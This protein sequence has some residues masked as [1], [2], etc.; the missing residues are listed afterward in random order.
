MRRFA[1]ILVALGLC[2]NAHSQATDSVP[3]LL[4]QLK[5]E[6]AEKRLE[7]LWELEAL[8]PKAAAAVPDLAKLLADVLDEEQRILATLALGKIGKASLPTIEKLLDNE[9][10]TSR[11]Y[12]V[13]VVSLI[14]KDA[15][16]LSPRILKMLDSDSD[17]EVRIKSMQALVRIA[18]EAPEV[19]AA[20]LKRIEGKQD[21]SSAERLAAITEARH[22]G[23]AALPALAKVMRETKIIHIESSGQVI[24]SFHYVLDRHKNDAFAEKALPYAVE[25]LTFPD[26]GFQPEPQSNDGLA[27]LLAKHGEKLL[28]ALEKLLGDKEPEKRHVAVRALGQMASLLH[29]RVENPELVKKTL[30][31]LKPH[32][33]STDRSMRAQALMHLPVTDETRPEVIRML[34]DADAQVR[35]QAQNRLSTFNIDPAPIVQER[36]K[37]AT[38]DERI[39]C[40][41]GMIQLVNDPTAYKFLWA[42]LGHKDA[43]LRLQIATELAL[44]RFP[45][46]GIPQKIDKQVVPVLLAGLKSDKAEERLQASIGLS[47]SQASNAA[48]LPSILDGLDDKSME[49]RMN[50]LNALQIPNRP[51]DP[52]KIVQKVAPLLRDPSLA[53]SAISVLGM[54]GPE[55]APVLAEF[56]ATDKDA[57]NWESACVYLAQMGP[58]AKS[59]VPAL[60]R[61]AEIK[62]RRRHVIETLAAIDA[63]GSYAA[64][65]DIVRKND[66]VVQKTLSY[67]KATLDDPTKLVEAML[68]DWQKADADASRAIGHTLAKVFPMMAAKPKYQA[69]LAISKQLTT[70]L[71]AVEKGLKSK[72]PKERKNA[73]GVLEPMQEL[74]QVLTTVQPPDAKFEGKE[75]QM[76]HEQLGK[77]HFK[78]ATLVG[79]ARGDSDLQV[80]REAR[81]LQALEIAGPPGVIRN[82][83]SIPLP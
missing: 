7:A 24:E 75:W 42:N 74:T 30:G 31:V 80:R 81:R 61:A 21:D 51:G 71:D 4:K 79:N 26:L 67:P 1:V 69:A 76:L 70:R 37:K 18:P 82:V 57:L 58:G 63:A 56:V 28:P 13:W 14:G 32:L 16:A 25:L 47:Q 34:F 83:F 10:E 54:A 22:L 66:E 73:L 55:A 17:E 27:W 36:W 77:H 2:I 45:D 64:V 15:N 23:A 68:K 41:L 49:V 3:K 59:A 65:L 33:Q 50:L 46:E 53:Q 44:P 62:E 5:S 39:R 9:D 35:D 38:G 12:A 78:M 19:Q 20:V 8:G 48:H 40:A 6:D 60:L 52:K 72:D 11:F 43:M 29:K